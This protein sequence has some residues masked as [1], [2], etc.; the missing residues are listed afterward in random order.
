M[1]GLSYAKTNGQTG[2]L[3]QTGAGA[4]PTVEDVAIPDYHFASLGELA[5]AAEQGK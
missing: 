3:C 5:D 4:T 2:S 1:V